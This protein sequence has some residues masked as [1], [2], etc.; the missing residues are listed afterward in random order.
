[1]AE[2]GLYYDQEYTQPVRQLEFKENFLE[3]LHGKTTKRI[4]NMIR[5]GTTAETDIYLRNEG[6][7]D[8]A[9]IGLTSTNPDL[10]LEIYDAGYL[11]QGEAIRIHVRCTPTDIKAVSGQIVV[12]AE[13][14]FR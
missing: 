14:I 10:E 6:M 2:F 9:L 5:V 11:R 7:N 12:D 13:E 8:L 1:M 4:Y 3:Y